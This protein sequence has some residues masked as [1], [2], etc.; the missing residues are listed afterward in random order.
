MLRIHCSVYTRAMATLSLRLS[1]YALVIFAFYLGLPQF[2]YGIALMIAMLIKCK[3]NPA[4]LFAPVES[5]EIKMPK[6]KLSMFG[7]TPVRS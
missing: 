1:V 7:S 6:F 5:L 2:H 3:D 4:K